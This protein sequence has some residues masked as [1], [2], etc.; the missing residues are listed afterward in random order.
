MELV[1]KEMYRVLKDDGKSTVVFHSSKASI[2]R[3]LM[4]AYENAGFSVNTSSILDK[5]QGSFKQVTSTVTVQGDPLLLLEKK[6]VKTKVKGKSYE[7]I[8]DDLLKIADLSNEDS[9]ERSQERLYS[10]FV[11]KMFR[12]KPTCFYEC[13]RFL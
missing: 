1:F 4:T 3:A 2:W 6:E 8:V 10:R 9:N 12:V 5:I 13:G 11:S 7:S